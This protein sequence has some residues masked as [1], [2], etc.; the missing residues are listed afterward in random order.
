VNWRT[1]QNI[2]DI[3][4]KNKPPGIPAHPY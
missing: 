4:Q 2:E 1:S 3:G